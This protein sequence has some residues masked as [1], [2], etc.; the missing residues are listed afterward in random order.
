MQTATQQST[1]EHRPLVGIANRTTP[2]LVHHEE[3]DPGE[4]IGFL[5]RASTITR[6]D[7]V[8][9]IESWDDE[10]SPLEDRSD[11]VFED[12]PRQ[13]TGEYSKS[14]CPQTA[15]ELSCYRRRPRCA[16]GYGG[17]R[18]SAASMGVV[19]GDGWYG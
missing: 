3:C 19:D 13:D 6:T 1:R 7:A 9:D 12:M 4:L 16:Y 15:T 14:P 18:A 2:S 8:S 17:Q 10:W 11:W 5:N